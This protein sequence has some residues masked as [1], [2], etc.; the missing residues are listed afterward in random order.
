MLIELSDFYLP[1]EV[2]HRDKQLKSIRDIFINFKK[3]KCGT[4]LAILGVTGGGKTT[5]MRKVI[6]EEDCSVYISCT[7]S[8]TTFKTIKS[9]FNL[10][11]Q[12]RAEALEKTIKNL[13][14]NPK[15]IVIDEIDKVKDISNLFDD[16]NTIYRKTMVP[17]IIITMNRGILSEM[18]IDAKKTLFFEKVTLPA[19]N[20]F[21]LKDILK[22]RIEQIKSDIPNIDDGAINYLAALASRNG[23]ARLLLYMTLRCLQKGNFHHEFIDDVYSEM[24]KQE[25]FGF[26]DDL[27]E[28]EKEFLRV[29]LNFCDD[30]KEIDAERIQHHIKLSQSRV[31]QLLNAFEKYNVIKTYH[32]NFGR[33][34]GRKR[35]I[36]FYSKEIHEELYNRIVY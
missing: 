6:N 25:W 5:I 2:L 10:N 8:K 1:K 23:S 31:S 28:N 3:Y 17:I 12:T 21:E 20:A 34:G 36:K 35:F 33:G 29:L 30:K 18:P 4:N 13:L 11:V 9:I 15:I 22:S 24:M 32:R 27:S 14:S 7:D 26:Y 19:Y 16:L